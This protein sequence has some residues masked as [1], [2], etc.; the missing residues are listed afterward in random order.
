[1]GTK[2]ILLKVKFRQKNYDFFSDDLTFSF[3]FH[4][5]PVEPNCF[6]RESSDFIT[7]IILS[8]NPQVCVCESRHSLG[9]KCV[10]RLLKPCW[11]LFLSPRPPHFEVGLLGKG[12]KYKKKKNRKPVGSSNP[13]CMSCMDQTYD[14]KSDSSDS[15]DKDTIK[16]RQQ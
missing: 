13:C 4:R 16:N 8:Y 10:R 3:D 14:N 12:S 6:R 5:A 11:T 2:R 9:Y 15:S 1:M 7:D